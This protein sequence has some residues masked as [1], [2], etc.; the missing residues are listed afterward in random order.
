VFI[1]TFTG[2]ASGSVPLSIGA[3]I[4]GAALGLGLVIALFPNPATTAEPAA[5][6]RPSTAPTIQETR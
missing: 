3:Q 4:I 2:I 1:D 5:V 6:S